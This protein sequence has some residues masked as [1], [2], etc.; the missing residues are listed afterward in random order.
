MSLSATGKTS[1]DVFRLD[2]NDLRDAAVTARL[3]A[4]KHVEVRF[5]EPIEGPVILG[6]GRWL[7]LG[8][9]VPVTEEA[10]STHAFGVFGGTW[11]IDESAPLV[12]ALRRAVMSRVSNELRTFKLPTYFTGHDESGAPVRGTSHDHL[13]YLAHDADGDGL[14]DCVAAIAPHLA[15]RTTDERSSHGHL[16]TLERALEGL[17]TI[18]AGKVGM[19]RLARVPVLP[20]ALLGPSRDWQSTTPYRPTRHPKKGIRSRR[21]ACP[22]SEARVHAAGVASAGGDTA[23]GGDRTKGRSSMPGALAISHS[24]RRPHYAWC[25]I[26]FR[27]GYVRNGTCR[28]RGRRLRGGGQT[29]RSTISC[30][31]S[32]GKASSARFSSPFGHVSR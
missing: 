17:T 2:E 30:V 22:R 26:A 18:H 8:V 3:E 5:S 21:L 4:A 11:P 25:R 20:D 23:Q 9:M 7:G 28:S 27:R 29:S 14:I 12:R 16:R 19:L 6:D 10:R 31:S 32:A 1:G 24:G 13:F 15:D